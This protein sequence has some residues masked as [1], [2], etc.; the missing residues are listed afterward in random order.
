MESITDHPLTPT[1]S[2]S[3]YLGKINSWRES[4][5]TSPS[6]LHLGH[7]KAM[8]ARH[9][10]SDLSDKDPRKAEFEH[11]RR[12][13]IKLH[14]QLLNYGLERGYS[15]VRW[16]Q[17]ANAMLFKEPGNFKIH[18]TR[19]IHLYE[20]DYNLAMG[21]K[22]K[23]A[24][25]NAE[26]AGELNSGQY[27]SR[28]SRGVHD[29]VFIE[30][31][32]LEISR[33][34]R[35][36]ILQTNYDA[37]SCYDRIIP[38]L[39][40][41]VS[42]KYGVPL[43]AVLT[44]VTTSLEAAKYKLKTELLGLS[45]Q[46]Y[47]HDSEQPIYGTGQGSGNSPMIWCFLSSVLLDCYD[48]QAFGA[49]YGLPD[50][51]LTTKINMI[52]Y[53]D[54]SN[55]QTNQFMY[56][57]EQPADEQIIQ[58]AQHDAQ[59]WHDILQV[60]GGALELPKCVYQILSWA[61]MLDGSPIPKG[62]DNTHKII[63]KDTKTN[64]DQEIQ[65][66]SAHTAHKTL[67]HYKDPAGNQHKQRKELKLKCKHAAEF[68]ST[69]P[70]NREEAWTYYFS[71]FQ[72]SVG[73]PLAASHFSKS[74]L[75]RAQRQFMSIL[76]AKCGYNRKTKREIIY[77]PA[78][79]GGANFRSLF[80]IQGTGQVLSFIKYW[81]SPSQAGKLLW[82][83][84][85]WTQY[86][87]GMSTPFLSE[88]GTPIPQMEV[89]WLKSLRGYLH[90]VGGSL[91][92]DRS[93]VPG[94][95]RAHDQ[96]IMDVIMQSTR[97][98][99]DEIRKLNYC[100]MYLQAVTLSDI[101][102]ATG[103]RLDMH[104]L[105]GNRDH[106][107]SS[108]T[109][110]HHI[111][112]QRPHDESWDLWRAANKL[113][114]DGDGY[115]YQPLTTWLSPTSKQRRQ[116]PTYAPD[117]AHRLYV[118]AD[119][120]TNLLQRRYRVRMWKTS[121][122]TGQLEL[123]DDVPD[124]DGLVPYVTTIPECAIPVTITKDSQGNILLAFT[125]RMT[126]TRFQLDIN[127]ISRAQIQ[128]DFH[129]YLRQL[130]DWETELLDNVSL[131]HD[132]FTTFEKM[133]N[134]F[135]AAGDGSVR[136][137][138]N[139]AFGW[140]ISTPAGERLVRANGPVRGHRPTSYRA[141]GYGILS[142]LRFV[143]RMLLYCQEDPTWTWEMTSD[144]T[145]LVDTVNGYE[146]ADKTQI[147]QQQE[148]LRQLPHDWSIWH[149]VSP[150]DIEEASP[151][152]WS[153]SKQSRTNT[154]LTPDW[155]VLNEIRWSMTHDGIKGG[156]LTHIKGHQDRKKKYHALTLRAQLNVDADAL[157]TAYQEAHGQALPFVLQF[158][159]AAIS[160]NFPNGT[161]TSHIPTALRHAESYQPLAQHIRN[162]NQWTQ[163]QFDS[164]N[165]AALQHAIK[166]K[167]QQRI[168]ITKLS[169]DLLPTNKT[170]YRH[171]PTEQKCPMCN[172]CCAQEDRDHVMR[173]ENDQRAAWRAETITVLDE[174]CQQL[175][176]EPGLA[177]ILVHGVSQ[178][179]NG[180]ETFSDVSN[181]PTKYH[182]L[183]S[184]QNNLGWRQLFNGRFCLEWARIQDDYV[185]I[186]KL[187]RSTLPNRR[188]RPGTNSPPI[189]L[190][191]GT[192]WTG[193]IIA[194]LWGQ[195]YKVWT[196]RNASIHGHSQETR[197]NR[198]REVDKRRLQTIYQQRHMLEPSVQDLL[199][200]S[201]EEHLQ[202]R[203]PNTIHNWL[204]IHDTTFI[205]SIKNVSKRA[206]QGVRSIKTYFTVRT[207]QH[208]LPSVTE[209]TQVRGQHSIQRKLTIPSYFA[210][211]RPPG[212]PASHRRVDDHEHQTTAI[213][214][215]SPA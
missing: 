84:V 11:Q 201:V 210:T 199:F 136:H 64:N 162:R 99:A 51:S 108:T 40:A 59:A 80:T 114:S 10:F 207:T 118:L 65:G 56:D 43:P 32:Q 112:Q 124:K 149:E 163:Q 189:R 176:T 147:R 212:N 93:Y 71:I 202:Q 173:C 213:D 91:Q 215:L 69:S 148:S 145:S 49:N 142:I 12:E 7:H 74:I 42:Q 57:Q 204:S 180:Q 31:F 67:G 52:G 178:W 144:N 179:L 36:T 3:E 188:R 203:S 68:M 166:R 2:Q 115:L 90:H 106:I 167:N 138:H 63:V 30:E 135:L 171:K 128:E 164:V 155:D 209:R 195:W 27:G 175:S 94:L 58:L 101:T 87:I 208:R 4:T 16:Q 29:P 159:H 25:V 38:N 97:F 214:Q 79:L 211:G 177:R 140:I 185:Y 190:R 121:R 183:I 53:V 200:P 132:I 193:E 46:W 72:T 139:G 192:Q 26:N 14:L 197:M 78:C 34:S 41:L 107:N 152:I 85:A 33:A 20:A 172:H 181:I 48:K 168:H 169:H 73:Y 76:I 125:K 66:I 133:Q 100:R 110:W 88:T 5:S 117:A 141:E 150:H 130:D 8:T 137:E 157:A 15:Y 44:N 45:D 92:L 60:S 54:D 47:T 105:H 23:A 205:Q 28:P 21:L 81:R 156:S 50:R 98:T 75:D 186:Q 134:G 104:M 17:V 35:K 83:A 120:P 95:E 55:G 196:M 6:G 109:T 1:I 82:I 153:I 158:P 161:C 62:Y 39:A 19:V 70:L 24:M 146:E 129:T 154:T 77:G 194:T 198:Q 191:S 111:N 89:K 113:W 61:F 165:W 126:L 86:S 170:L 143:K 182:R 102:N 18:R 103:D 22:W 37:S 131:T 184:Y 119:N 9:E 174:R 116:W 151:V 206:I 122:E 127:D 160:L 123:R 187:K 13:I 96:Y